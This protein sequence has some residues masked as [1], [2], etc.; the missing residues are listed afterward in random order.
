M[1]IAR[2]A[3]GS[4]AAVVL[5]FGT[6][7]PASADGPIEGEV[8]TAESI[9]VDDS[10]ELPAA[11]EPNFGTQ[12]VKSSAQSNEVE[13]VVT[14][15]ATP[16]RY[17]PEVGESL[18]VQY[19][20]AVSVVVRPMASCTVSATAI[21]PTKRSSTTVYA[22]AGV[23]FTVS[24]GCSSKGYGSR[25]NLS[26]KNILGNFPVKS[27]N[28]GT[29]Y[30]GVSITR[31]TSVACKSSAAKTW[32]SAGSISKNPTGSGGFDSASSRAPDRTLSC[33]A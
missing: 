1:R 28:A 15:R 32:R 10:I 8:V 18:T 25:A 23:K 7:L 27:T 21:T 17:V 14:E 22:S 19:D 29:T 2:F 9:Q 13:Q 24:S 20:N 30:P 12:K 33:S 6:S 31:Y 3:I 16:E 11:P 5:A 26:M 4:C